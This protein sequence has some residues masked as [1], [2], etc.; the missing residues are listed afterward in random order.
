MSFH[1]IR[2]IKELFERYDDTHNFT[3]DVCRREVFA[4][5]RI[6]KTCMKELPFNNGAICPFCGRKTGESGACLDCKE[7]PLACAK[8]RSVFV[9][10]GKAMEMVLRF[11]RGEK[12]FC[13][14]FA[15]VALPV[16]ESEF[17]EADVLTFVPMTAKAEKRRS[18]NQS[19]LFC[20]QLA[21]LSGKPVKALL[22][23]KKET[24]QQK[25]LG[26]RE[27]EENL[28]GCFSVTEKEEVKGKRVLLIDD[29]LTTGATANE[30]AT[31]LKK[32]GALAVY[33]LT[34]TSVPRKD[35]FGKIPKA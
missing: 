10:E 7:K 1:P 18:Y 30:I 14:T 28:T 33:V 16:L 9:H 26:R 19:Q 34:V 27:R 22:I 8:A 5:E 15:S 6:C 2:K 23:K 12:Y 11:K 29:V 25:S 24:P 3:C 32:A 4:G 21:R 35:P 17:P 13:R 20:N 31:I